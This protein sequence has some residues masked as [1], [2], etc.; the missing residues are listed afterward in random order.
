MLNMEGMVNRMD[1]LDKE[2]IW[3]RVD[4]VDILG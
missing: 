4:K 1:R 3:E 2:D